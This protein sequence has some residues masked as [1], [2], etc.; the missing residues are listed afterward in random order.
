M[1]LRC[2]IFGLIGLFILPVS[3]V[4]AR[5]GNRHDAIN[6][7]SRDFRPEHCSVPWRDAELVR[8]TSNAACV[9]GRSWGVDRRGIWVDKG[10]GGTFVEAGRGHYRDH[11]RDRD[12]DRGEWR[13][14]AGWDRTI[15]VRCDSND[16]RYHF[17]RVDTGR[18]S[19]V[20]VR[21][22]ISNTRCVEGRTWGWN[23]A[24]IWVDNGCAA[25]FTIDRRWR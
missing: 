17:C 20:E 2:A 8:Q 18:G 5:G 14:G 12:R 4:H 24:G 10:C 22:Q 11:D 21:R 23:R 6:C 16:F 3:V 7:T 13:P 19:R 15:A 1:I 9:R 25:V